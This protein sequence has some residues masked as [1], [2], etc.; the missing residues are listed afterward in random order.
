MTT[1]DGYA[2]VLPRFRMRRLQ[3]RIGTQG[4]SHPRHRAARRLLDLL[5]GRARRTGGRRYP[6]FT[7]R[8]GR[9]PVWIVTR[10]TAPR[11]VELLF[12]RYA[13]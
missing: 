4:G 11:R 2:I 6:V 5:V 1:R 10:A 8:A 7:S 9:R 12:V 3:R 13:P